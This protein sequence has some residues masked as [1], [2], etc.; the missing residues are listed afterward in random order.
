MQILPWISV[1]CSRCGQP[2]PLVPGSDVLCAACQQRLPTYYRGRS[3]FRYAFPIDSAL[4]SL[5]FG[6]QLTYAP[7]IGELL[8]PTFNEAFADIDMLIPVPLHRRRHVARGFNQSAEICRTLAERTDR[9]IGTRVIRR[10][11]TRTQSGLSAS[12]RRRNLLNAFEVRG[13][14]AADYP[15]IV[16]DVITTG[17]TCESLALALLAAGAK[18][19]G[20]LTVARSSIRALQ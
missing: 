5:K 16:D 7:A 12:R 17:A 6:R 18:R 8:L 20:V 10:R 2:V 14:L 19:V 9:P 11:H 3:P 1:F 13:A 4:K 15:L